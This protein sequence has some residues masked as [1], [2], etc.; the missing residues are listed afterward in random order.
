MF[1]FFRRQE[2]TKRIF[3]VKEW[4]LSN[5]IPSIHAPGFGIQTLS[6]CSSSRKTT[7]A[8]G[9]ILLIINKKYN[10]RLSVQSYPWVGI[11]TRG[12][13]GNVESCMKSGNAV[14]RYLISFSPEMH[15]DLSESH[16]NPKNAIFDEMFSTLRRD[17]SECRHSTTTDR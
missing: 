12:N 9:N 11:K 10:H 2:C 16:C 1:C 14:R 15:R 3:R 4:N 8:P 17:I 13:L 5:L 7:P 6:R